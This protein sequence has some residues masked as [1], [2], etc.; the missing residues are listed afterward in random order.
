MKSW[1]RNTH[2]PVVTGKEDTMAYRFLWSASVACAAAF[3][4]AV[5]APPARAAGAYD[6][7]WVIDIP[8]SVQGNLTTAA[9]PALRL[10]VKIADSQVSA[11]LERVPSGT[12]NT[13]ENGTAR[14]ATPL[15]GAVAQDG[16]VVAQW[17]GFKANGKLAGDNGAVTVIGQCGPRN[18][19]AIRVAK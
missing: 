13:V 8:A 2:L 3:A 7:T 17:E 12:S 4:V 5:S 10:Q 19:T 11:S 16:T 15:T 1:R 14:N 6:G 9:C 18:A